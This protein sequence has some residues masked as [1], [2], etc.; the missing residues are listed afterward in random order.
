MQTQK[1][2]IVVPYRDRELH[3]KEFVPHM[4]QT[5]YDQK[6]PFGIIIVEQFDDKPFN[7]AKLLNVG[8]K[9]TESFDYFAFHDVDMLPEK[10]DYSYVTNPTHLATEVEQFGW[11]LAYDAYFGGV[12]VFDKESFLTINGFSN[13]FA[14]GW[15]GED[16]FLFNRCTK[17]KIPLSRKNCRYRSLS[18]DRNIDRDL[19]MKTLEVLKKPDNIIDDGISNLLYDKLSEENITK[20]TKRIKVN[21]YPEKKEDL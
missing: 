12:T 15:G 3:L 11:R 19:Y 8:F 10:S 2:S 5:L 6:I 13:L 20:F 17:M 14:F 18:H 21:I 16:D 4:E 9:E 7:R 1:L